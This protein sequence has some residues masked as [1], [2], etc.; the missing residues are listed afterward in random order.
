MTKVKLQQLSQL[1][2]ELLSEWGYSQDG[3]SVDIDSVLELVYK[4]I[5]EK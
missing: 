2:H 1:L 4:L 3:D 5:E